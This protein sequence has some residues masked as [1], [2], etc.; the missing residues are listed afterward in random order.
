[1]KVELLRRYR[2]ALA[3]ISAVLQMSAIVYDHV[4]LKVSGI[5]PGV[6]TQISGASVRS[7]SPNSSPNGRQ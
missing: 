7:R 4:H 1:M 3:A 5:I 2:G 6:K